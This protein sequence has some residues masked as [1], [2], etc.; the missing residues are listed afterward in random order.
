MPTYDELDTAIDAIHP[1][2]KR[3]ELLLLGVATTPEPVAQFDWDGIF[4]QAWL[5]SLP[6]LEDE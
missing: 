3:Y 6:E 1:V 2:L 5:P 4:R